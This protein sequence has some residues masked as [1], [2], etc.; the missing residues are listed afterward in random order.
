M[1]V[2]EPFDPLSKD[3]IALLQQSLQLLGQATFSLKG[4]QVPEVNRVLQAQGNVIQGL[5]DGSLVITRGEGP[6]EG[7]VPPVVAPTEGGGV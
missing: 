4:G 1:N 2:N 6:V 7:G 5:S 3:I